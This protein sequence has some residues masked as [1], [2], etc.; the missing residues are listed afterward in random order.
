MHGNVSER[1]RQNIDT[2]DIMSSPKKKSF[3]FQNVFILK[4]LHFK[5]CYFFYYTNLSNKTLF[6]KNNK[7]VLLHDRHFMLVDLVF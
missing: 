5:F 3:F 6:L 2:I 1:K 7:T 4:C